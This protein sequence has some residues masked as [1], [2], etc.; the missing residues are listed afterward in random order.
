MAFIRRY[1]E[2]INKVIYRLFSKQDITHQFLCCDK[3]SLIIQAKEQ[4][5]I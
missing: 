1:L 2:A 5:E 4:G 3:K